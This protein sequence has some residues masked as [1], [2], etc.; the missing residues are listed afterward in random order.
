MAL[1]IVMLITALGTFIYGEY[2]KAVYMENYASA[3]SAM[4]EGVST[5]EDCGN[6]IKAV[7]NNAI[8]EE[9]DE[10]TDKYTR[11]NGKFVDFNDA[12]SNLNADEEFQK[13]LNNVG[14]N[15]NEVRHAMK[16]LRGY[17]GEQEKEYDVINDLYESYVDLTTLVLYQH[18]SLNSFSEDFSNFDNDL[19]KKF[20]TALMYV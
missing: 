17:T 7:W 19:V 3:L 14:E 11:V 10:S 9:S 1:V 13:K 8:Y 2:S 20:N 18:G 5:A 6:L 12:I 15:C 4:E 16:E